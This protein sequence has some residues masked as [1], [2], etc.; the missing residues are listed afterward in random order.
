MENNILHGLKS[1]SFF[2]CFCFTKIIVAKRNVSRNNC[3]STPHQNNSLQV[4][5]VIIFDVVAT[6]QGTDP[7]PSIV[8]QQWQEWSCEGET[9]TVCQDQLELGS[10]ATNK[11]NI[12]MVRIHDLK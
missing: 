11:F 3:L 1:M 4:H 9:L 12:P 5:S 8:V 7:G 10:S 6:P 2:F